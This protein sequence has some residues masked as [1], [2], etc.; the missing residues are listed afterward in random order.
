[1]INKFFKLI[2][3]KYSRFLRFIFFL[4]Y[5]FAIFIISIG[6]FLTIPNFF[7][8]EKRADIIK[9][10]LSEIY[11]F[12]IQNYSKINFHALPLPI[13]EFR[14][15]DINFDNSPL[16]IKVENLKIYPKLLSIYN[17]ENYQSNKLI[18]KDNNINLQI[19]DFDYVT[20]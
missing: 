16:N 6:L 19:T 8:Y 9:K 4:R 13:I 5:L 18:L 2:H 1:M 3:N 14:N 20:K 12:K 7:N 11:D 15:A 10:H 17:Y